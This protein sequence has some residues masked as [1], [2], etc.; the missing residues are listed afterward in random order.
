MRRW[1]FEDVLFL[2]CVAASVP[3]A[4]LLRAA[5]AGCSTPRRPWWILA[6]IVGVHAAVAIVSCRRAPAAARTA[7]PLEDGPHAIGAP[8][9]HPA[10]ARDRAPVPVRSSR[11]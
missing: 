6:A 10:A 2:A 7:N 3:A 8:A 11:E 9:F 1:R 4:I 5:R